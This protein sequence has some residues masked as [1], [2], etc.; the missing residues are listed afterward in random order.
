MAARSRTRLTKRIVDDM[1]PGQTIWDSEVRGFGVRRQIVDRS[2]VLKCRIERK[3]IFVTLGK[4]GAQL[5]VEQARK[6]ALVAL[7]TLLRGDTPSRT[8]NHEPD[9]LSVALFCTRYLSDHAEQHKKPRSISSDRSLIHNHIIPLLGSIHMAAVTRQH[10]EG[11]RNDVLV[12]KTAPADRKAKQL[13]Q[14]GGQPVRGG[15]GVA[16]RC[17]TLLSKMFNLAEDWGLRPQNSNPV[18]RIKR[19]REQRCERFLS[20]DEL[21]RIGSALDD[22]QNSGRIDIY[23]AT[24]IR[25]LVLTGA[26]LN[27]VLS[28]EWSWVDLNRRLLLLP[29]S[30]TGR[31]AIKLSQPAIDVLTA[32]PRLELNPF[33]IVGARPGRHLVNLQKPWQRICDTARVEKV[34]LHDLRHTFA[35]IAAS[36]GNSLPTIGALLGHRSSL[37]AARYAH[38]QQDHVVAAND[39]VGTALSAALKSKKDSKRSKTPNFPDLH[40]RQFIR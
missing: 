32:T 14:R 33:V 4:H 19:Y 15:A 25:L 20:F 12:G 22:C 17:L 13:S 11:L 8:E 9:E 31:K 16:N 18:R 27:E 5:T 29:D 24:A 26:R 1:Q 34:R 6:K 39:A 30:K 21:S 36:Q 3:Q 35:S 10:I 7:A 37:T 40:P 23:A 38:L 2:Y 28:L